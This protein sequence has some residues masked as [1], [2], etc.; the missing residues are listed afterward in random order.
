MKESRKQKIIMEVYNKLEKQSESYIQK[1]V[2]LQQIARDKGQNSN[3]LIKKNGKQI[4]LIIFIRYFSILAQNEQKCLSR[5]LKGFDI[6][7]T[8]NYDL[9]NLININHLI[10][11]YRILIYRDSAISETTKFLEKFFGFDEHKKQLE[12]QEFYKIL[13]E[14]CLKTSEQQENATQQKQFLNIKNQ[15]EIHGIF[16]FDPHNKNLQF[17]KVEK[18]REIFNTGLI[19]IYEVLD[20]IISIPVPG[21]QLTMLQI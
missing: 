5:I 1:H 14:T 4:L 17:L 12:K 9:K 8:T 21:K 15:F 20:Q 11:F 6:F 2:D 7:Y 13:K 3:Q 10:T 18:F 16:D 19:N